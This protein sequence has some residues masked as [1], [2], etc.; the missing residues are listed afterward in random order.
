MNMTRLTKNSAL[1]GVSVPFAMGTLCVILGAPTAVAGPQLG[2][3]DL[4]VTPGD[5][6]S[7]PALN[8][9]SLLRPPASWSWQMPAPSLDF[10]AGIGRRLVAGIN[11]DAGVSVAHIPGS[12]FLEPRQVNDAAAPEINYRDYFLGVSYGSLDGKIWYL[13]E[14]PHLDVQPSAAMY[15]EAGWVGP[16]NS[17]L[18]VSVR[19]GH[20]EGTAASRLLGGGRSANVPSLSLGASTT[21]SG[22]GLGLRLIDGGGRMFGGEQDL[23]LM[24]SISKPLR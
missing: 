5:R 15:Y 17:N 1:R 4:W 8:G 14:N 21:L 2:G 3:M 20:Y 6:T 22:Y 10:A 11:L 16:L 23:Q 12:T 7:L 19:L 18:S 13:P 9:P 24:G